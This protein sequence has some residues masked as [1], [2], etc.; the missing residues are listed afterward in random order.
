MSKWLLWLH[1]I[2]TNQETDTESQESHR[3]SYSAFD[4]PGVK[5]LSVTYT[6]QVHS[7]SINVYEWLHTSLTVQQILRFFNNH[8]DFMLHAV[9]ISKDNEPNQSISISN[10]KIPEYYILS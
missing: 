4:R 10:D 1:V 9:Q 3:T 8:P 5:G 7:Y 2:E 6:L